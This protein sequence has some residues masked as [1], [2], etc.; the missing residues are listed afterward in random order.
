M[1]DQGFANQPAG[2]N[3]VRFRD[4]SLVE[5]AEGTFAQLMALFAAW[6]ADIDSE[7]FAYSDEELLRSWR[8]ARLDCPM[9]PAP[10]VES[11]DPPA[12]TSP[13]WT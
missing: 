8:P 2:N 5:E 12:A 3:Q 9:H 13:H 7:P 6:R 10:A 1:A 4:V 11:P